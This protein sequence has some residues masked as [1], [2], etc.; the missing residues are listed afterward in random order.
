ML[1]GLRAALPDRQFCGL[2]LRPEALEFARGLNTGCELRVG[3]LY[4]LPFTDGEFE[5]TICLE[6]LEHLEDPARALREIARVTQNDV[7]L[8]VPW[9]PFFSLGNLARGHH[10]RRCGRDPDHRNFWSLREF[11]RLVGTV[12]T[13]R[14]AEVFFPW[15]IVT[16][17]K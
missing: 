15:I 1:Q 2:D 6:V 16:A 14:H 13:I 17:R 5:L 3:S 4:A 9:E 8:S 7:V 12:L 10:V 11:T